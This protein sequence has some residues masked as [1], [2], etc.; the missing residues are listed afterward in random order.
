MGILEQQKLAN[1]NRM[2]N[3]MSNIDF[4]MIR[5]EPSMADRALQVGILAT[6]REAN[7]Q[8]LER[9]AMNLRGGVLRQEP[10]MMQKIGGAIAD[11]A[12]PDRY[13]PSSVMSPRLDM[14][15]LE[16]LRCA[17][18]NIADVPN[19]VP[20][21]MDTMPMAGITAFHGA[22]HK[23]SKFDMGKVGVGQGAQSYGHGLYFAENPKVAKEYANILGHKGW[24]YTPEVE[25]KYRGLYNDLEGQWKSLESLREKKLGE[26]YFTPDGYEHLKDYDHPEVLPIMNQMEGLEEQ[27]VRLDN[28]MKSE[29]GREITSSTFYKVDI[30]DE[31]IDKMLDWDKPLS[32]Q[33]S[34]MLKLNNQA[35]NDAVLA[36]I[37]KDIDKEGRGVG[38][39][40]YRGEDLLRDYESYGGLSQPEI[41]NRLQQQGIK[42]IK[43]LDQ[44]SRGAGKGTQNF[45]VFDDQIPQILE[46][47]ENPLVQNLMR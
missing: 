45:V 24:E 37:L 23:F 43:Y 6:Q 44:G 26:S 34:V 32:E 4:G 22:P 17:P 18:V 10:S 35:K 30:P 7:R 46:I 40:K 11:Y 16:S 3:A 5:Q 20:M 33:K 15:K 29:G 25:K 31:H 8:A 1:E 9:D 19:P 41:S 47:N 38:G 13:L 2:R 42:G 12:V 28:K 39:T 14:S 21:L 27:L 36:D